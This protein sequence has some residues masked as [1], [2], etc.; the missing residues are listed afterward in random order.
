M[1]TA[2]I[3]KL[4]SEGH[5]SV[6]SLEKKWDEAK[7]K[8]LKQGKA[9][10]YGLI[11]HIF[12]Q[13]VGAATVPLEA[14]QRLAATSTGRWP[15]TSIVGSNTPKSGIEA[16]HKFVPNQKYVSIMDIPAFG[17]RVVTEGRKLARQYPDVV[18]ALRNV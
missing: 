7:A 12:Q 14:K 16:A 6:E 17:K 3:K 1:P 4:A 9:D 5:G 18:E 11:T 2:Y 10:N 13:M 15:S 8:A